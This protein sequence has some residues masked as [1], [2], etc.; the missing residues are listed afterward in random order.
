MWRTGGGPR[1]IEIFQMIAQC[2]CE[3]AKI[4]MLFFDLEKCVDCL[5]AKDPVIFSSST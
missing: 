5:S 3:N 1:V 2:E 4:T